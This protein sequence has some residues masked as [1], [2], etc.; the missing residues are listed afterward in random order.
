M[1]GVVCSWHAHSCRVAWDLYFFFILLASEAASLCGVCWDLHSLRHAPHHNR[2]TECNTPGFASEL[3]RREIGPV[4][5]QG[6]S[7]D[8]LAGSRSLPMCKH[9]Q[10]RGSY[11]VGDGIRS[12]PACMHLRRFLGEHHC[13]V[14]LLH[15]PTRSKRHV[16]STPPPA[17]QFPPTAIIFEKNFGHPIVQWRHQYGQDRCKTTTMSASRT[18][19]AFIAFSPLRSDTNIV[20][21]AQTSTCS[22]LCFP[23]FSCSSSS[24]LVASQQ[25]CS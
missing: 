1:L 5:T 25:H 16:R 9:I 7:L 14:P 11:S 17:P 20:H 3:S 23:S 19:S 24:V 6:T 13:K 15:F 12:T 8:S 21:S 22:S 2:S 4:C 10:Q 18:M